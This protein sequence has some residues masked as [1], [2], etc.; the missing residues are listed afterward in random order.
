MGYLLSIAI[1]SSIILTLI[2]IC[3]KLLMADERQFRLN[4]ITLY[5][6]YLV[7]VGVPLYYYLRPAPQ[8]INTLHEALIEVDLQGIETG[9]IVNDTPAWPEVLVWIY[10]IGIFLGLVRF[11]YSLV[12]IACIIRRGKRRSYPG[13]SSLIITEDTSLSPFSFIKYIVLS[14]K[15]YEALSDMV[16][17]HEDTHIRERHWVDL[18]FANLFAIFQ[19]FNP[20][21]WLMIEEFKNLHEYQADDSVI[22]SGK[23]MKEY[24]YMLIKKAVGERLPSP[25]NS[26]NH[27]KLKKRVTMMYKKKPRFMRRVAAVATVPALI[28]GIA[29]VNSSAVASVLSETRSVSLFPADSRISSEEGLVATV[30]ENDNEMSGKVTNYSSVI[31]ND[32]SEKSNS[33]DNSGDYFNNEASKDNLALNQ[34]QV[35]D[36]DSNDSGKS[37]SDSNPESTMALTA[38]IS[39][40]AGEEKPKDVYV[41]VEEM[42]EFPGGMKGLM[43]F[44]SQNIRYPESAMRH[45]IQGRVIIKF[46]ITKDGTV[47]NPEVVKGVDRDLDAEAVRVVKMLPKWTPAKV[48]NVA[49][50]SYF[51]LPVAFK[52]QTPVEKKDSTSLEVIRYN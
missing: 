41:Q 42:A 9:V 34:D 11:I 32:D 44:L 45:E 19:W 35:L 10:M 46:I 13:S 43:T 2:F 15:D 38:V 25:A 27:S 24:Q 31:G 3:Y 20:A 5:G 29:I 51:T 37:V 52:I 49:V 8:R 47:E 36:S 21:A 22:Q 40:A 1:A 39:S 14:D 48:N 50:D 30:S 18:T 4:R 17:L 6:I 7:S 12:K 26:L 23:D 16:I 28:A 33:T